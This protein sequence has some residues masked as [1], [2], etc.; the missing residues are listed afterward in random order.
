MTAFLKW[1]LAIAVLLI[2][3][4]GENLRE[5]KIADE[6]KL[7]E[8]IKDKKGL[9]VEPAALHSVGAGRDGLRA[10]RGQHDEWQDDRPG[11]R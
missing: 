2:I 4:C 8:E 3:G 6:K 10:R 5:Q 9:T 1:L 11:H 7:F